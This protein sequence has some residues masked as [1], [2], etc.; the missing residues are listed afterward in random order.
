MFFGRFYLWSLE[1]ILT[2]YIITIF[3][4]KYVFII[5]K[6]NFK[7]FLIIFGGSKKCK[8]MHKKMHKNDL[9]T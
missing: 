3:G 7:K 6:K 8:K 4:L 1:A 9:R 2:K 5:L